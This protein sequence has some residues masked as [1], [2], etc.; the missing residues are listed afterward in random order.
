MEIGHPTT[1]TFST[2]LICTNPDSVAKRKENSFKSSPANRTLRPDSHPP[3]SV[4]MFGVSSFCIF[5][6]VPLPASITGTTPS[7]CR[8]SGIHNPDL[9]AASA[10][11]PDRSFRCTPAPSGS[12]RRE[13]SAR[14]L[15]RH[16]PDAPFPLMI[17][18]QLCILVLGLTGHNKSTPSPSVSEARASVPSGDALST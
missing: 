18:L 7:A 16:H 17:F 13:T 6:G 12:P 10:T 1:N 15:S 5:D 2:R 8:R 3:P 14:A 11:L 4:L 9:H